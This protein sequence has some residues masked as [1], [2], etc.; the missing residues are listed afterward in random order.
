MC[1]APGSCLNATYFPNCVLILVAS[2]SI[3]GLKHKCSNARSKN[4]DWS[5]HSIS[6]WFDQDYLS[7]NVFSL[8]GMWAA[9]RFFLWIIACSQ[10]FITWWWH[11]I[12]CD[13][14]VLLMQWI[15]VVLSDMTLMCLWLVLTNDFWSSKIIFSSRTLICISF[16]S[17]SHA[18]PVHTLP[19]E[20]PQPL[21][22]ASV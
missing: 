18:P 8:P 15:A 16:S 9:R 5:I 14:T 21:R 11:S 3:P 22:E 13:V 6:T 10:N 12:E 20:A 2:W 7:A 4:F 17:R 1:I 19:M